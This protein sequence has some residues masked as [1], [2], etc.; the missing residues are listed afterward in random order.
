[1]IGGVDPLQPLTV[2]HTAYGNLYLFVAIDRTTKFAFTELHVKAT[3]RVAVGDF[4]RAL[5]RPYLCPDGPPDGRVH[6]IPEKWKPPLFWATVD[7][8][9]AGNLTESQPA[10]LNGQS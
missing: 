4:L 8:S 9:M 2:K 6:L 7:V 5:G 1:M 10:L 3:T